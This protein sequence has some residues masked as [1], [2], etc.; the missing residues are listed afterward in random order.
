MSGFG[1]QSKRSFVVDE[2]TKEILHGQPH[3]PPS[4]HD[5]H[6]GHHHPH[7]G[8]DHDAEFRIHVNTKPVKIRDHHHT[9][10]EIKEAAIEQGVNIQL[11]FVLSEELSKDR[12]R[13]IGDDERIEVNEHSRF[14]AIPNDDHS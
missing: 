6:H 7:H 5:H 3:G 9:G 2:E 10:L 13:V 14:D 11:D 12:T 8:H 4:E 1:S